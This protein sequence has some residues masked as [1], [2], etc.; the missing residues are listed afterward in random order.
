MKAQSFHYESKNGDSVYDGI[1]EVKGSKVLNSQILDD[2]G[3]ERQFLA[4]AVEA[5][6]KADPG[7]MKDGLV[8]T[9]KGGVAVP[10]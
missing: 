3:G 10:N 6:W 1:L 5:F 4:D 9:N 8:F 2:E 7:A